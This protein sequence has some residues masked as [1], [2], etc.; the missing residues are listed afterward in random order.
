EHQTLRRRKDGSVLPVSILAAPI[1]HDNH[2]VAFYSIYRDLSPL[3]DI[4]ARLEQTQARLDVVVSQAPIALFILD[5]SATFTFIAGKA[6]ETAGLASTQLLGHCAYDL[7]KE[8]P[9]IL[10]AVGQALRGERSTTV[11]AFRGLTYEIQCS[12]V[13]DA[14]GTGVGIFGW[15]A[16]SPKRSWR[17]SSSSSWPTTT[18][19]RVCRTGCCSMTACRKLCIGP[20]AAE[21]KLRCC[22]SIWTDSSR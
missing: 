18:C 19:S 7:F 10:T 3:Q 11:T 13:L 20:S 15:S 16:M 4:A 22:S 5:E 14:A 12:P 2:V 1:V 6:L 9:D 21:P 8:F 17:A